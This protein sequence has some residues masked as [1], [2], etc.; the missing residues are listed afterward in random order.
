[1]AVASGQQL[2]VVDDQQVEP[3]G[4]FSRRARAA[5]WLIGSAGVS[6]M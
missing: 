5:T 3:R 4:R 6:S 1:L 2:Q